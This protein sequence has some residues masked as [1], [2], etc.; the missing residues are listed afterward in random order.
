ME[1]ILIVLVV[2]LTCAALAGDRR[3]IAIR[4]TKV[5]SERLNDDMFQAWPIRTET[6]L[7]T[8]FS[9]QAARS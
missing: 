4:L 6:L 1:T 5:L 9:L 8:K 3:S 7:S 2:P